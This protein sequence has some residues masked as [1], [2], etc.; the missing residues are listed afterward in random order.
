MDI[1]LKRTRETLEATREY[2]GYSSEV[3]VAIEELNELA[4][5]L[6]KYP[7]YETHTEAINALRKR[8]LEEAADVLSV[9]DHV[10]TVFEIS[11]NDL[12]KEAGRKGDR[13]A[14]RLRAE[15]E[16]KDPDELDNMPEKP[17]PLC[18]YNGGDPFVLPCLSC[19]TQQG[20]YKGFTPSKR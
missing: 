15:Q 9:L 8:V 12:I 5:V 7:R 6:A 10:Q 17:C 11:D 14:L 3:M 4:C 2:Y 20:F 19:Y 13:L 18:L 16:N 1:L